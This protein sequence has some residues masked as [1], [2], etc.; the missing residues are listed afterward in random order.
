MWTLIVLICSQRKTKV[1]WGSVMWLIS[2]S[3]YSEGT[4]WVWGSHADLWASAETL[5]FSCMWAEGL[6]GRRFCSFLPYFIKEHLY[7]D[8]RQRRK[9]HC[10]TSS[11]CTSAVQFLPLRHT[12]ADTQ[13]L[14][15]EQKHR[16][17][18][19][20]YDILRRQKWWLSLLKSCNS[21]QPKNNTVTCI[22]AMK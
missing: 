1:S 7:L 16:S 17:Q 21:E 4:V 14:H 10:P 8:L 2:W 18:K 3:H 22:N 15:L 5:G 20:N 6:L 12:E 9:K 13:T 11:T 19:R